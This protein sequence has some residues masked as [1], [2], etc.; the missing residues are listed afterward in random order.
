MNVDEADETAEP[1]EADG[2]GERTWIA[3]QADLLTLEDG[4]GA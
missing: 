1:R 4:L 2:A 3:E